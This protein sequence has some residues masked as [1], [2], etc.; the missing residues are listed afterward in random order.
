MVAALLEIWEETVMPCS[1]S[2]KRV[3]RSGETHTARGIEA[4]GKFMRATRTPT[5]R[6]KTTGRV[7]VKEQNRER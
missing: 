3:A 7:K 5:L 1:Y 4:S 6:L 2:E